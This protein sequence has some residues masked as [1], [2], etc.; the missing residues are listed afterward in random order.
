MANGIQVL[1]SLDRFAGLRQ[2]ALN[3]VSGLN[4]QQQQ[5]KQLQDAQL[6]NQIILQ[7]QQGGQLG[8]PGLG[9]LGS[10]QTAGGA[11]AFGNLLA[12]QAQP[13]PGFT[14]PQGSTRFTAGGQPIASVAAV[15]EPARPKAGAL[16][17]ATVNDPSGLPEGT[18]F[19]FDPQNNVK[20]ISQPGGEGLTG[21]D[22]ISIAVSESKAFRTDER[23]A[24]LNIIERSERGMQA[25]L[26]QSK[27]AKSRIASDQAL[28]V[29]FQ[30]MLDP[31]SVVRESEFARTPQ[32]AALINRVIGGAEQ[33]IKGGLKMTNEDRDALVTMA[34]KLLDEAKLTA[35]KAFSEF[36][37]RADEINLN[38]K[39]VFGGFKPF[40][41]SQP[42]TT[43]PSRAGI[44][45]G[46]QG[47]RSPQ[48]ETRMQE[49]L[50]K[51]GQ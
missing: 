21:K 17:I 31:T 42:D 3:L 12:Q 50:R 24:N 5:Q 1:P 11:G 23:V 16:Q 10:F 41:V 34:Q 28:G 35:N 27:T 46:N 45:G 13:Q 30:K 20:I 51:Q 44:L 29:L 39:I 33:I 4:Q 36:E 47:V 7:Q 2:G 32:G 25:A 40:D 8:T 26:R 9:G 49:L 19:Q 48:Q 14:L 22:R 15:Q 43:A 6:L 38:K 37:T 18:V